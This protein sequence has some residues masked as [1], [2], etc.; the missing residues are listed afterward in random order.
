[1][2]WLNFRDAKQIGIEVIHWESVQP[3]SKPAE[4]PTPLHNAT[5][6]DLAMRARS[7]VTGIQSR[8][9]D[10]NSAGLGWLDSLYAH[11]VDYYGKHLSR[12]AVLAEKRRF[13][14]RWPGRAYK[15]KANSMM[16]QCSAS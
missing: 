5:G 2:T 3:T 1:M 10:S 12:D 11:E 7:F 15:I 6:A 13:A 14:E 8:W 4:P 16:A 9:S